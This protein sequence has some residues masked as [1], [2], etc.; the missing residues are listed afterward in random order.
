MSGIVHLSRAA[1]YTAPAQT[2]HTH[3]MQSLFGTG[4]QVT[5]H[6]HMYNSSWM[7][8]TYACES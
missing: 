2:T 8:V 3:M 6:I 7:T 1:G 5:N 4:K